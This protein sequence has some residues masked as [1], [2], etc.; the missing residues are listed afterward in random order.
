MIGRSEGDQRLEEWLGEPLLAFFEWLP[1]LSSRVYGRI[2]IDSYLIVGRQSAVG[3]PADRL[4][5]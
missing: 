5:C 1:S 2:K 3:V 4:H